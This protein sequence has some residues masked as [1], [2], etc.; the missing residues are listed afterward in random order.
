[1]MRFFEILKT[2]KVKVLLDQAIY[3]GGGFWVT[4]LLAKNLSLSDFGLY[5]TVILISYL[6]I[7]FTS[8]III[9]PFQVEIS[10]TDNINTYTTFT[11]I[12]QIV[13][14]ILILLVLFITLQFKWLLAFKNVGGSA[15]IFTAGV[16]MHDYFRKIFLAQGQ[17]SKVLAIDFI[18]VASQLLVLFV[19]IYTETCT[20]NNTLLF[21][22]ASYVISV[23][24]SLVMT[25]LQVISKL[26]FITFLKLHISQGSWLFLVATLQWCSSNFFVMVSGIYVGIEALAAFRLVQSM[27]GVLNMLLQTF[28]NYVLPSLSRIHAKSEEKA[29]RYLKNITLQAGLIF[30]GVLVVLFVFSTP[31]IVLT[32][33]EKYVSYG[34]VIQLMTLLYAIIYMGYPFRMI[35]RVLIMNK[36]FFV[37]YLLSFLFSVSSFH[38]LLQRF[39]LG[40]AVLG[41]VINQVLMI[42]YWYYQLLQRKYYL[43]K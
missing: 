24:I 12:L 25:S 37:G 14:V 8:S 9:Q 42:V 31:I 36:S 40:G 21:L 6:L 13:S 23:T 15:L 18:S 1:M 10:K 20:L 19:L 17:V 2:S 5:S 3:S 38:F 11:L 4:I 41:L 34:Y 7:S 29:K 30:L 22:G 39:S 33:G 43:W 16:L 32:G 26:H 28:E 35:I 27:F